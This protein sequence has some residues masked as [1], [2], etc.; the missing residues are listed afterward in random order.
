MSN[1]DK[2]FKEDAV[3]Y[4]F[5]IKFLHLFKIIKYQLFERILLFKTTKDRTHNSYPTS[6]IFLT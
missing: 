5:C 6:F 2:K 1:Y 3:G 4:Y